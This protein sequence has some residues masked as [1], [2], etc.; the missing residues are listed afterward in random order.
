MGIKGGITTEKPKID[1]KEAAAIMVCVIGA[2]LALYFFFSRL[3]YTFLPFIIAYILAYPVRAAAGFVSKKTRMPYKLWSVV[4]VI[5]LVSGLFVGI[6]F[7]CRALFMQASR[8]LSWLQENPNALSDI[9]DSIAQRLVGVF[10]CLPFL[11]G[12]GGMSPDALFSETA[13]KMLSYLT[14]AAA[15]AVTALPRI[16]FFIAVT[17]ISAIYFSMDLTQ[18]NATIRS[19]LP[20][21]W[22]QKLSLLKSGAIR[23]GLRFFRSYCI[24]FAA[25]FLLLWIGLFLLRQEYALLLAFI[26][27]I[28]DLLPIVGIGVTLLP[29]ALYSLIVGNMWLG[30]GLILLYVALTLFRQFLEPRLI[31]G[32]IGL[33]PLLTLFSMVLGITL[34]GFFGMLLAPLLVVTLKGLIASTE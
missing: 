7:L 14:G 21:K 31:G 23:T 25:N 20:E 12:N 33:H 4:F 1:F 10:S 24:I 34:F 19:I 26:F 8:F 9:Y 17:V 6:F 15:S 13:S 5:L 11:S 29:W 3:V 22:R 18:I 2:G 32:G 16:L 27:A 28:V 30:V